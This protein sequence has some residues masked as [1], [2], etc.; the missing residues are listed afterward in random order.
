MKA[1]FKVV[2]LALLTLTLSAVVQDQFT[3][4]TNIGTITGYTG[5]SGAVTIP[6][7]INGCP[8]CQHRVRCFR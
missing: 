6:D 5:P 8:V 2:L 7:T 1:S 3:F 4:T